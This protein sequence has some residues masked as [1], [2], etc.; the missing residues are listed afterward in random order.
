MYLFLCKLSK[1]QVRI[2]VLKHIPI[3]LLTQGGR[4]ALVQKMENIKV[5]RTIYC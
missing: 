4:F 1:W 5:T 3:I 2:Q